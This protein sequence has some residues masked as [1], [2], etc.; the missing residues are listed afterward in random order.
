MSNPKSHHLVFAGQKQRVALARA[1]YAQPDV[2]LLDDPFSALDAAT[3]T[4][5][6][7]YLVHGPR[8]LFAN[9]AVILVTHAAH[10]IR[11]VDNILLI[12]DGGNEFFGPW[13]RL[14]TFETKK[15]TVASAISSIQSAVAEEADGD[16]DLKS[17]ALATSRFQMETNDKAEPVK[18][19]KNQLITKEEREHG[20]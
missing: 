3:G 9:S 20:M 19:R 7:E 8:A 10:F 4:R 17:T 2:V 6:F 12:V 13:S 1:A 18:N 5:V 16:T 15:S 11:Q 14:E